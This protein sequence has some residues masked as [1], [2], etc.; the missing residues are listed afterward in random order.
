MPSSAQAARNTMFAEVAAGASA[1]SGSGGDA[2][3]KKIVVRGCDPVMASHARSM[4]PPLLGNVQLADA[5]DDDAFFALLAKERF[6][7]VLFAPGACRWDR[8]R[9]PIPG[10]NSESHGWTLEQY[11]ARV[12]EL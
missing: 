3:R 4:L 10:G 2:S 6:D 7:V 9:K 5:T 12:R 11:H 1:S 8:A